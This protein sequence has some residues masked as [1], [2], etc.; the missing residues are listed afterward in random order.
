VDEDLDPLA[1]SRFM[2]PWTDEFLKLSGPAFMISRWM[3]TTRGSR[4]RMSAAMK[5]LRV[6]LESTIARMRF[7]GTWS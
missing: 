3:P 1:L 4:A 5:S 6:V 2:T 7:C